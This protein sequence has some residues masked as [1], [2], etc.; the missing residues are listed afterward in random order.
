M[1]LRHLRYFLAVAEHGNFNKASKALFVAQPALSRR[2]KD[3]ERELGVVLFERLPRGVVLTP[4]GRVLAEHACRIF[5]E[6]ESARRHIESVAA[7]RIGTLRLGMN[8][9]GSNCVIVPRAIRNF[10]LA[11]P[12]VDLRMTTMVSPDQIEALRQR[13]LDIGLLYSEPESHRDMKFEKLEEY[14]LMLAVTPD[15]SLA[16]RRTVQLRD[17]A[18]EKF[19]WISRRKFPWIH[20]RL[21]GAFLEKGISPRIVQETAGMEPQ[22]NLLSAGMGVGLV[23]SSLASQHR[24]N[25]KLIPVTD[26]DFIWPLYL[27]WIREG[28]SPLTLNFVETV[29]AEREKKTGKAAK[30]RR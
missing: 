13:T 16:G 21:I 5:T 25:L 26:L 9:I 12:A 28:A 6:I 15:H 19:V 18:E 27:V 2:V 8:D 29:L 1:E 3:L 7:G 20:D 14:T 30:A 4:E 17:L 10:K 11:F 23:H 24:P 22:L